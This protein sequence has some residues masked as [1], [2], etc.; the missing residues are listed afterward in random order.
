MKLMVKVRLT[1]VTIIV[2]V[3]RAEVRVVGDK[4]ERRN[5]INR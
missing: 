3:I 4:T 5:S 1:T 2:A